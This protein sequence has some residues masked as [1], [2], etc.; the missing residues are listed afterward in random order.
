MTLGTGWSKY[1]S[2]DT[3]DYH[4]LAEALIQIPDFREAVIAYYNATFA[5]QANALI[6]ENGTIYGYADCLADSA[7]MNFVLWPYIRV[8]D[9]NNAEHIWKNTT[10]ASV[11]AD[12]QNWLTQRIAKLDMTFAETVFVTGDVNGDGVVNISDAVALLRYLAGDESVN[13]IIGN[14]DMNGDG[15]VNISDAVTLLRRLAGYND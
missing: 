5:P 11:L 10:Y 13:I 8:G 6:T 7:E 12:M 2:P 4:Y 3:T 15:T 1:I 14:S 9:P